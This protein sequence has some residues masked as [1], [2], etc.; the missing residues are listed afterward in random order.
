MS[1]DRQTDAAMR[2]DVTLRGTITMPSPAPKEDRITPAR[3][4]IKPRLHRYSVIA[5]IVVGAGLIVLGFVQLTVYLLQ[6]R[7]MQNQATISANQLTFSERTERSIL[8]VND[9]HFP[10]SEPVAGPN[11]LSFLIEI[12]NVGRSVAV[13]DELVV[14]PA[15]HVHHLG[16]PQTPDYFANRV[17]V[18]APPVAP[19]AT[20]YV[21]PQIDQVIGRGPNVPNV[22]TNADQRLSGIK[23]GDMPF[24]VYGYVKYKVGINA[25]WDGVT[26]YC[27]R[28]VPISMRANRQFQF[29]PCEQVLYTYAY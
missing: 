29:A 6:T 24:D 28:Y 12:K 23:S 22:T 19:G 1:D 10:N 15:F 27:Y 5:N 17:Q 14:I 25:R 18:V 4:R 16:L 26:G 2:A 20:F 3:D 13:V 11:G 7:I 21:T 8:I 9:L